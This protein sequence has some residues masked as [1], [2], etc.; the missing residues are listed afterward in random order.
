MPPTQRASTSATAPTMDLT[1]MCLHPLTDGRRPARPG[2]HH[3]SATRMKAMAATV[4]AVRAADNA[5]REE[6]EDAES[7]DRGRG[8]IELGG[9]DL[10]RR[11]EQAQAARRA[12]CACR[13]DGR[14]S[15][16]NPGTVVGQPERLLHR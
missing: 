11:G 14:T 9:N 6:S 7:D 2:P 8:G 1:P 15:G 10:G 4:R 13:D 5:A 16:A 3:G 12:I